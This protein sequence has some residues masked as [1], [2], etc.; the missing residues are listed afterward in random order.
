MILDDGGDLTTLV[1]E[2]FPQYLDGIYGVS[3]ET[4]TGVHHLYRAA[5]EGKLKL[6]AIN[7]NDSVTKSKFDNY[8]SFSEIAVPG[9]GVDHV[10][11]PFQDATCCAL[12]LADEASTA[13]A[14]RSSTA[15]SVLPTS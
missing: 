7:V 1:H 6:A 13:A 3:E 11:H 10:F 9:T 15:S 14:S 2:K 12:P 8:V 4:T 5:K